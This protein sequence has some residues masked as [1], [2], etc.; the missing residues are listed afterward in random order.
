[1]HAHAVRRGTQH[2]HTE[3]PREGIRRKPGGTAQRKAAAAVIVGRSAPERRARRAAQPF[4]AVH[5]Q[6]NRSALA[7]REQNAEP[8]APHPQIA[9]PFCN[10]EKAFRAL[11]PFAGQFF[12]L[13][14]GGAAVVFVLCRSGR[15]IGIPVANLLHGGFL[16]SVRI[17]NAVA[18]EIEVGRAVAEVPA[19]TQHTP[20]A[21]IGAPERLIHIVPDKPALRLR[22]FLGQ[23]DIAFHTAERIAHIVHILTENERLG[24]FAFKVSADFLRFCVHPALDVGDGI[25][26]AVV[27]HTLI[28]DQPAGV[29][30]TEEPA[31][32][33]DIFPRVALVAAGPEQ[34]G[35][36]VFI[37]LKHRARAVHH[38]VLPFGQTAR[39][40][41]GRFHGAEFLP[42]TVALEVC[43]INHVDTV[44]IA[45]M[46]PQRLVGVMAGAHRVD[47]VFAENR[48]CIAHILFGHGAAR[49]RIPLMTVDAAEHHP[50]AVEAHHAVKEFKPAE[51]R[52]IRDN[53]LHGAGGIGEGEG[54]TVEHRV[55]VA[56]GA[57]ARQCDGRP[58][59][60]G[61]L[62][63]CI[64]KAVGDGT[65]HRGAV[66]LT[67]QAQARGERAGRIV[68]K[69]P[70]AE[71]E[72]LKMHRRFG[73]EEHRAENAG[74]PE[75]VLV[76]NPG[77]RTALVDF[78]AQTVAGIPQKRGQIKVRGGKTVLRVA[79]KTAVAPQI[80]RLLHAFKTHADPL[81]AERF[82]KVK[83]TDIAAH[84]VIVPIHLRRAQFRTAVPGVEG[85]R[86]LNIAAALHLD[87]ARH[88]DGAKA[89]QVGILAPEFGGAAAW[90]AAPGKPPLPV[91][92]LAQAALACSGLGGA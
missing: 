11:C 7:D 62:I 66:R 46:I 40:I 72:V 35:R 39:H 53:L 26:L 51:A 47:V 10:G 88:P 30:L 52:L 76:L 17:D 45:Q 32:R 21:G 74:E 56:P 55:L 41:P 83:L 38:A 22:I 82:V 75:K 57:D 8:A 18:A 43:L 78:H 71:P 34:N 15:G 12:V 73:V 67:A 36:V 90:A 1:M 61:S 33:K 59:L 5:T 25:E 85:V 20:A 2:F 64:A 27:D 29:L 79:D 63:Q 69:Q 16:G 24:G 37:A 92:A 13:L 80:E 3:I 44:F 68:R 58:L 50:L 65:A 48:H 19:V 42:G 89:R 49:P 54:H 6:R 31:H 28:V 77:S 4:G 9:V 87:M 60:H 91:K 23:A 86:V 14:C 84:G 70:G 81:A